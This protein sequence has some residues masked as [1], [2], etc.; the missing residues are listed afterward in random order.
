MFPHSLRNWSLYLIYVLYN[1][2]IFIIY[3]ITFLNSLSYKM[4]I[5]LLTNLIN[6]IYSS[7]FRLI[8]VNYIIDQLQSYILII[9]YWYIYICYWQRPWSLEYLKLTTNRKQCIFC[10]LLIQTCCRVN[11]WCFKGDRAITKD[12]ECENRHVTPNV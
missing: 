9:W 2:I 1:N 4:T 3:I 10:I 12:Y 6:L 7:K 5:L 8:L 11:Y